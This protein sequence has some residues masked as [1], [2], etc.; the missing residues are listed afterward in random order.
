MGI[1]SAFK[2]LTWCL[3]YLLL[4]SEQEAMVK[5]RKTMILIISY[6]VQKIPSFCSPPSA[7][8]LFFLP[9]PELHKHILSPLLFISENLF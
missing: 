1:N 3:I 7:I 6:I 4:P 5:I 9:F 8:A 2:G